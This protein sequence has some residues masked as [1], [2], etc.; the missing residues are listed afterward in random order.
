MDPREKL[1]LGK[2][3]EPQYGNFCGSSRRCGTEE[4]E[5]ITG[6]CLQ[7]VD[8]LDAVC[9]LHDKEDG[10]KDPFADFKMVGRLFQ[11]NPFKKFEQP[12]YGRLYNYVLAPIGIGLRGLVT[13]PLRL[14][15]GMGK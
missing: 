12:V 11:V 2:Y 1:G 15:T 5:G 10:L 4:A 13:T 9:V 14:I 8:G 3:F 6:V 7:P